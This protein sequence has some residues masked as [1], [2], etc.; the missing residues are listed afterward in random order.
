MEKSV[1][2]VGCVLVFSLVAA[3]GAEAEAQKPPATAV[4]T[5]APADAAAAAPIA[6]APVAQCAPTGDVLF[7]VDTNMLAD[8]PKSEVLYG[9]GAF[10][11]TTG[12]GKDATGCLSAGDLATIKRDLAGASW[13]SSPRTG[14][15][16]HMVHAPTNYVVQGKTVYSD[17][18]CSSAV[19]DAESARALAEISSLLTAAENTVVASPPPVNAGGQVCGTRGAAACPAGLFCEYSVDAMC[20][21]TDKPGHCASKPEACTAHAEPVC[22]CDGKTY[23]NACNAAAAG[24][25]VKSNGACR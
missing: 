15:R 19:L 13:Q 21:A 5:A 16:C 11:V 18:G 12:D 23:G 14:I 9:N 1:A 3:C 20:G 22:G 4:V 10:R 17:V 2:F 24:V 25:S 7:R 8:G 6:A